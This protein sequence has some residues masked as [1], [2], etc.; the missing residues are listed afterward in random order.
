MPGTITREELQ[1]AI[2]DGSVTVLDAL[3]AAPYGARHLPGS[4]NLAAEDLDGRLDEILDER[5]APLVVYSTDSACTRGPELAERLEGLGFTDVRV[6]PDGIEG[7][8][9][10]GLPVETP[11]AVRLDLDDMLIAAR[12]STCRC[13]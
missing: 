7:W 11:R 12:G 3:P 8:V 5:S 6:Y 10:A 4:L 13:S 1:A 9:A 2:D